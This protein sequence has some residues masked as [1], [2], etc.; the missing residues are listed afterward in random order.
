MMEP[1]FELIPFPDTDIPE[2]KITGKIVREQAI[3][4]VHYSIQG[5][6]DLIL[7][8]AISPQPGRKHE[9]WKTTCFEF[10][11]AV[12]NQSPYWEFNLSPSGDWNVFRMDA[13]RQIELR[14]EELVQP[15]HLEFKKDC[16]Y[17]EAA[18]DLSSILDSSMKVEAGIATVIQSRD[19]H[20]TY[21][22]LTHPSHLADFHLRESFILQ[23]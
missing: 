7:V 11:L 20:L 16:F 8:P 23:V 19:G 10:F 4:T 1:S 21:W 9:L 15:H 2:I 12:P 13:Y 6:T 17:L 22:S 14:E 5:R 3:L 18:F